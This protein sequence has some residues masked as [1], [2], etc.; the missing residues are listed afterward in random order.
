MGSMITGLFGWLPFVRAARQEANPSMEATFRVW[1]DILIPADETPSASQLGVDEAL[2]EKG[3]ADTEYREVLVRG[4][5]WLDRQ[6]RERGSSDFLSLAEAD[7]FTI[8]SRAA[9]AGTD[10][11]EGIFFAITRAD[12]FIDYYARP[13]GW[14]GLS[15]YHGPPQPL[16]YMDFY[17]SPGD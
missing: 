17:R 8:A 4:V 16:G 2:L 14:R 6:A 12:A 9:S 15:G 10:T 3:Q 7:R 1:L 11:L 13:E 5:A